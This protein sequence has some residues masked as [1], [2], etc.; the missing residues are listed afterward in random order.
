MSIKM[1]TNTPGRKVVEAPQ[2]GGTETLVVEAVL[3]EAVG[4]TKAYS[5]RVDDV[6]VATIWRR[7]ASQHIRYAHAG[8][9]GDR[10]YLLDGHGYTFA[11][12]IFDI[13]TAGAGY[14][15]TQKG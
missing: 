10:E 15:N 13:A 4:S 5:L 2:N 8:T 3:T 1:T 12:A 6:E 14:L 9:T 7:G 11:R